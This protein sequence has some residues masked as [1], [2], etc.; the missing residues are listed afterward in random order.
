MITLAQPWFLLLILFPVVIGYLLPHSVLAL[1]AAL[2][3]PFYQAM[4]PLIE[5]EEHTPI[6]KPFF[7]LFTVIWL[8]LVLALA[9]P[10]WIG[11]P[12]P[13]VRDGRN[14]MLVLDLSGSMELN[15]MALQG[16]LVSRLE[17]VK[18]AAKQFIKARL[19]DKIGLILFG[20]RAYLQTP[21]TYDHHNVLLRLE[22]ATVGLAGN[23]TSIGD[24][25]GLAVK[26]LQAVPAQGRVIILLTDG[27]NNSGML[28]PLKAA[29]LAQVDNIKVYTIGL[30]ADV[31]P[32]VLN[33]IF[34]DF[35][36]SADLDEHSLQQVANLTGGRYFRATDPK[37]L[38]AIYTMINHLETLTQPQASLRP[39]QDY[40]LW[41]LTA[42]LLLLI[43]WLLIKANFFRNF[44]NR[45]RL[46][47]Y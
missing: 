36:T 21:L 5:Q 46:S 25:L 8:L 3:V 2:K 18:L 7:N 40:Y 41:P 43:Y 35:N 1:P 33:G 39:Q 38:Q 23:T 22:E 44:L 26:H 47:E 15:D 4:L 9:G 11:E 37:S 12:I 10:R 45:P 13:L 42:A 24:A 27:A 14:I 32:Q 28:T 30:G 6:S 29:E 31:D 34:F 17:V 19:N 16:Q 20:S